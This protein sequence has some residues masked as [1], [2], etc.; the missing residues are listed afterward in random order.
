MV[1]SCFQLRHIKHK[2][3][4][5]FFDVGASLKHCSCRLQRTKPCGSFSPKTDKM[6]TGLEQILPHTANPACANEGYKCPLTKTPLEVCIPEQTL[7]SLIF[8]YFTDLIFGVL[9]DH[10]HSNDGVMLF[11]CMDPKFPTSHESFPP[12][13]INLQITPHP[14]YPNYVHSIR[15]L[16]L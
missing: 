3:S 7:Y 14:D 12:S 5:S 11:M 6:L 10:H 8:N 1:H 9:I 13:F 4:A 16:D 15:A 2:W